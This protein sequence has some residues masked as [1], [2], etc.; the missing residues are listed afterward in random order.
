MGVKA[1]LLDPPDLVD[2][3]PDELWVV[4]EHVPVDGPGPED[5]VVVVELVVAGLGKHTG[6]IVRYVEIDRYINKW[7]DIR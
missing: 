3:V 7:I 6:L 1:D 2:V 5:F 4:E